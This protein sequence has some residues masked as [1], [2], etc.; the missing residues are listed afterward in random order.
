MKRSSS[1]P[2]T[3]SAASSANN[4]FIGLSLIAAILFLYTFGLIESVW[5]LPTPNHRS[6]SWLRKL[7]K[8]Q[9][10]VSFAGN[11]NIAKSGLLDVNEKEGG[12]DDVDEED[13]EEQLN[14][15]PIPEAQWP[16]SIRDEDGNFEEVI[17]P[18]HKAK[19]HPDVLMMLPRF[20]I[21]DPVSIHQ[22]TLM[23]RD[24]AMK[25]GSCINPDEHGTKARGDDCPLSQRTVYVAIASYRDWQC[26]DTVT[27]IFSRAKHPERVRVGVVDQIVEGEDGPCDA[28]YKPCS[29]DPE[30]TLCK[31]KSQLDVFQVDAPLSIG[32]VFARHIGH[33]MYRGEY[34]YMQ[35]DA[36]VTF[37]RNW[38]EDIISQQES[39]KNEMAV[40]STYLTDIDGS[41]DKNGDSLRDTR[42]IMCNTDY[43]EGQDN[44]YLRHGSQPEAQPTI[45]GT[46]QLQ[47]YWA[48]GYSFSRG[49][50]VV[51]VPYDFYQPMIFQ[52]EEM[53]I[54]IRGFTIG[55]DFYAPERSVCFH[56]YA[57]GKNAKARNKVPHYWENTN[58]YAGSGVKAMFRLLGIVHMNPEVKSDRWDHSEEDKYG[59]GG[60][61]TPELFYDTFGI[62][63]RNKVT[64]HHLCSFVETGRMHNEFTKFL[65]PDG[66]GIDYSKITYRFKDPYAKKVQ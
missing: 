15:G 28:P 33:R 5:H 42:P 60:V 8:R 41:I 51:N 10:N 43:E 22:N 55:Y 6:R 47:P 37:T 48:A 34:Y 11:I 26:R 46:P 12:T 20:W 25:I 7:T 9:G 40:L 30:Q 64:E 59:L 66:M 38:D 56:H 57:E 2:T 32:P 4:N 61:R 21:N 63:V 29:E 36:H 23:S 58:Q 3:T 45:H 44:R 17:H 31:Y 62:D 50:F 27:S 54:G 24:L 1:H 16:V 19:G 65:R 39:T 35:S 14:K 53:S 49:H 52:G 13:E 18:G